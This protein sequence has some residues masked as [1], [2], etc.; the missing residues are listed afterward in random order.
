MPHAGLPRRAVVPSNK[1]LTERC[2][3][4]VDSP[5]LKAPIW[6]LCSFYGTTS[7]IRGMADFEREGTS[8]LQAKVPDQIASRISRTADSR[9]W[10]NTKQV[11]SVS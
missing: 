7:D 3:G 8:A 4:S 1:C 2:A 11:M 6:A 10:M 5:F 9:P